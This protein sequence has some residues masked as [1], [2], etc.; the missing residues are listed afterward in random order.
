M[1]NPKLF[2]KMAAMKKYNPTKLNKRLKLFNKN[3]NLKK[4][5]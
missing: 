4:E 1:K 5:A 2:L 3:S